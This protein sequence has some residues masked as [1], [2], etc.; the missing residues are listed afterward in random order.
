MFSLL[1]PLMFLQSNRIASI[2]MARKFRWIHETGTNTIKLGIALWCCFVD[3]KEDFW[4]SW[5]RIQGRRSQTGAKDD[6]CADAVSIVFSFELNKMFYNCF[7][8]FFW[9]AILFPFSLWFH[10][11]QLWSTPSSVK[12]YLI[13]NNLDMLSQWN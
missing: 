1:W 9:L 10:L 6:S 4:F 2:T 7:S 8:Q 3:W 12:S 11:H 5:M 13:T